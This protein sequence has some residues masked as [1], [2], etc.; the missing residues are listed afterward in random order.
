M[1]RVIGCSLI[2]WWGSCMWIQA[3]PEVDHPNRMYYQEDRVSLV[4]ALKELET[5]YGQTLV[6]TV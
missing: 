3:L 4:E 5:H 1:K 2:L 6:F